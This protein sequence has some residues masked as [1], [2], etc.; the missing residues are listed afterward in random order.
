M[1][2]KSDSINTYEFKDYYKILTADHLHFPKKIFV[3]S[4]KVKENFQYT[5]EKNTEWWDSKDLKKH[6]S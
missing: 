3:G 4:K 5:S 6:I 2:S 1:I